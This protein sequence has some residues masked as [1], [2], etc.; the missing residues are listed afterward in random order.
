[1]VYRFKDYL[2]SDKTAAAHFANNHANYDSFAWF[3][4]PEDSK[5]WTLYYT[6]NR[7]SGL[8][9][10]SNAA[11]IDKRL[12]K[13]LKHDCL[14]RAEHHSHWAC[15]WVEGYAIRVYT[16]KGR[17][18]KVFMEFLEILREM[19]NYPVLNEDDWTNREYEATIAS[20]REIGRRMVNENAPE[21]WPYEVYS[22][23]PDSEKEPKGDQGGYPSDES[24]KAALTRL[25]YGHVSYT[26]A[27]RPKHWTVKL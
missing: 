18:T 19:D 6:Q 2:S 24:V 9:D 22:A 11:Q 23:L 26:V 1:M 5:N 3:S 20:I 16:P 14:I 17:I 21:D 12:E 10:Q 4:E 27:S 13:F 15:G 8:L 7:D 25:G